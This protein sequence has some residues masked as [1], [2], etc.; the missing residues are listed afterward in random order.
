MLTCCVINIEKFHLNI[1]VSSPDTVS[2]LC[3][4]HWLSGN[5]AKF[6][7]IYNG[8][9][10]SEIFGKLIGVN[11]ICLSYRPI[12]LYFLLWSGSFLENHG[13]KKF[14]DTKI[15]GFDQHDEEETRHSF[16]TNSSMVFYKRESRDRNLY[17]RGPA[18]AIIL[19]WRS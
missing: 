11:K 15:S 7:A 2:W 8:A 18:T 12:G 13:Y 9:M 19:V 4:L 14:S 17:C 6:C 10:K 3:E 5:R 16:D 1:A